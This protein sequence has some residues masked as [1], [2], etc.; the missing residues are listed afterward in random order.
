MVEKRIDDEK[1]KLENII[2]LQRLEISKYE[3]LV[4]N[5][6]NRII[7][8][9]KKSKEQTQSTL[10]ASDLLVEDSDFTD[11]TNS[12]LDL[13]YER[14]P[15]LI[16]WDEAKKDMNFHSNLLNTNITLKNDKNYF[17]L[18]I[19]ESFPSNIYNISL[20]VEMN[21]SEFDYE[22]SSSFSKG[23]LYYLSNLNF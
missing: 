2:K 8:L 20:S 21:Y 19:I 23:E 15:N 17:D 7:L 9:E 13:S 16:E 1:E 4:Q 18:E 5:L 10:G 22:I 6:K 14:P 12:S 11:K 3:L